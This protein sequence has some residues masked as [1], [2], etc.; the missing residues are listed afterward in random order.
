MTGGGAYSHSTSSGTVGGAPFAASATGWSWTVGGGI[1]NAI[2][3]AWS[4]KGEYLYIDTPDKTPIPA[5][6][7]VTGSAQSHII[8][9]GVNYHF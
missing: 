2:T 7:A 9:L 6:A 3:N 5:G 1:E 4:I 8:R